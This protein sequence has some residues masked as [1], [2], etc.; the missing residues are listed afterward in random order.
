LIYQITKG[1]ITQY[2]ALKLIDE[3]EFYHILQDHQKRIE[4]EAKHP[5]MPFF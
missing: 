3:E 4:F 2:E 1:D 5:R